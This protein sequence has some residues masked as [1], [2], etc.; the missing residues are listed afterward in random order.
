[1]VSLTRQSTLSQYL[2]FN[3]KT[4]KN[5]MSYLNSCSILKNGEFRQNSRGN[6]YWN[7]YDKNSDNSLQHLSFHP[8]GSHST[9]GAIHFKYRNP[10]L[11][12]KTY[13]FRIYIVRSNKNVDGK[14]FGRHIIIDV[15]ELKYIE[16]DIERIAPPDLYNEYRIEYNNCYHMIESI[17]NCLSNFLDAYNISNYI[18]E[19]YLRQPLARFRKNKTKKKKIKKK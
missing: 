14:R 3:N 16:N 2:F 8:R 12:N 18:E 11:H 13:N 9:L 6:I 1:M 4:K 7:S 15:R 10:E 19:T 5:L 17:G